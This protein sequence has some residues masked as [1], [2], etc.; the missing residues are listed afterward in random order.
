MGCAAS[1][2]NRRAAGSHPAACAVVVL[3]AALTA[4]IPAT[5][6]HGQQPE[7]AGPLVS[8][9]DV[10][11]TIIV[12]ARYFG[13]HN[14][15]GR[16]VAGYEEPLCL[17]TTEAARALAAVQAELRPFGLSLKTYDCYRPQRAVD[18]FVAWARQPADT[19]MKAEFY[20]HVDKANLFSDGYIAERSG[21]SRGST[22]DL[23]LVPLPP[24]H[25][26]T[27][28]PGQPLVRCTEPAGRR[29]ADN[30]LDMGTGFDCFD[31]LSHTENP[32]TGPEAARNRL[33]LRSLMEKHGFRNYPMEW[34]H[35]TLRDEPFPSTWFDL[36]V[37]R[38][39]D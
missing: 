24:P 5:R 8:I 16:P 27:W 36:P 22:V 1:W 9:A 3:G 12:E 11:P 33:L 38:T 39:R 32:A 28:T 26:P 34:W 20:P 35:F 2:R 25:Q 29:F 30:S 14:F 15:L 18:D 19:V 7:A 21:H 17:L 10:D 37:R 13:A 6:Q 31:P 23:T 4:C